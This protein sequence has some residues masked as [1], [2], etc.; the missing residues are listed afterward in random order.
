MSRKEDLIEFITLVPADHKV[1]IYYID[2]ELKILHFKVYTVA[3][4]PQL[5]KVLNL[6][7][8]DL[9]DQVIRVMDW[10]SSMSEQQLTEIYDKKVDQL[11]DS[12]SMF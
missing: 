4:I 11:R 5:K 3:E 7:D 12:Q 8:D 6:L 10:K 9:E 2:K 1:G